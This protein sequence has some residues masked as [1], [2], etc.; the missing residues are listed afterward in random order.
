[1]SNS[2]HT[3]AI[4]LCQFY[5]FSQPSQPATQQP[6]QFAIN[7]TRHRISSKTTTKP[8]TRKKAKA[9]KNQTETESGNSTPIRF[10]LSHHHPPP[11][12]Y[13]IHS[14][15]H[16][17]PNPAFPTT[18]AAAAPPPPPYRSFVVGT[19]ATLLL[20]LTFS[21]TL[22]RFV[23][24]GHATGCL[25]RFSYQTNPHDSPSAASSL[26]SSPLLSHSCAWTRTFVGR[27]NL[28]T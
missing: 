15:F 2:A 8:T 23:A 4:F 5:L 18:A 11:Q 12:P 21:R 22:P 16:L 19:T 7:S 20:C 28:C 24:V 25:A 26:L 17:T 14:Q 10:S 13:P 1:M 27:M 9:M 6:Q 3:P